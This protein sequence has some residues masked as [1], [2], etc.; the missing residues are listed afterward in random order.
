MVRVLVRV[1][2]CGEGGGARVQG[3]MIV[4]DR[5]ASVHIVHVVRRTRRAVSTLKPRLDRTAPM[6]EARESSQPKI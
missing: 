4:E 2:G 6:Q 3:K 5:R 1:C